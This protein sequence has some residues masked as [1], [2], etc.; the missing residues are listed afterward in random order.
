MDKR[1]TMHLDGDVGR[2]Y[3]SEGFEHGKVKF[4]TNKTENIPMWA[5]NHFIKTSSD[6]YCKLATIALMAEV[7]CNYS[8][9]EFFISVESAPLIAK[10]ND[11]K[12]ALLNIAEKEVVKYD[13]DNQDGFW[14]VFNSKERPVVFV[15]LM[16][17]QDIQILYDPM[18]S[19]GFKIEEMSYHSPFNGNSS[20][21]LS[22][23]ADLFFQRA[24]YTNE[25]RESDL[26][27]ISEAY[28]AS[29]SASD[30]IASLARTASILAD[31]RLPAGH[32][33]YLETEYQKQLK[34]HAEINDIYDTTLSRI[35]LTL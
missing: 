5:V 15:R 20:G 4:S 31:P 27:V 14:S 28:R 21:I 24:K 25:K 17:N 7:L 3:H 12:Q 8:D 34:K 11:F 13:L 33:A 30:N 6:R 23:L 10:D 19:D 1:K 26:R 22:V 29:A 18:S 16:L 2:F 35:N 32:R 9:A